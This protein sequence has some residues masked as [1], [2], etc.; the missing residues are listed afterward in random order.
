MHVEIEYLT[1]KRVAQVL[2]VSEPTVRNYATT[3]EQYGHT[4][5]KKKNARLWT[6]YDIQ[7]VEEIME[8]YSRT[9]YDLDKCFHYVVVKHNKG[10]EAAQEILKTNQIDPP[11][12]ANLLDLA[13]QNIIRAQEDQA[14][15]VLDELAE[16]KQ[17]IHTAGDSKTLE[18]ENAALKRELADKEEAL[19]ALKGE[20]EHVK[21][22]SIFQFMKW[23]G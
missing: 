17:M 7:I 23:R 5:K 22:L 14:Q 2:R 13:E 9:D 19:Q 8:M 21:T 10:E 16:L 18:Q 3:L 15:A 20:I 4:F 12:D 6:A 11:M 1:T